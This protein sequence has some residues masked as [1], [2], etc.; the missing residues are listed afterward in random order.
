MS[1]DIDIF[2]SL[3]DVSRKNPGTKFAIR[4]EGSGSRLLFHPDDR[5]VAQR[6]AS[7]ITEQMKENLAA[8]RGPDG[9]ALP[10]IDADTAVRR[11]ELAEQGGRGG[12]AAERYVD[13]G[14][15]ATV[16]RQYDRQYVGKRG[17]LAGKVF[18]PVAGGPRGVVSGMLA[19][20]VFT[21]PDRSGKGFT[22]YVAGARS[23]ALP[24]VLGGVPMWSGAGM[25]QEKVRAA[26]REAAHR[27]L[28]KSVVSI[29]GSAMRVLD[30]VGD[31]A[32]DE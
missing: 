2:A 18:T 11:E 26:M 13:P 4:V 30:E 6:L 5:E 10:G 7:A 19:A 16:R 15:R 32:E 31:L 28:G 25:Q 27:I 29:L 24:R 21:R 1:Q 22:C 23:T 20:S 8:G 3:R 9:V 14:Y 12:E 17:A